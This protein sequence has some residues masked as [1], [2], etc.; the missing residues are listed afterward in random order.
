MNNEIIFETIGES[1]R[2]KAAKFKQMRKEELKE[3]G[4]FEYIP[5]VGCTPLEIPISIITTDDSY[6]GHFL[7]KGEDGKNYQA[8]KG[9]RLAMIEKYM[10]NTKNPYL[11]HFA[12][13]I[14]ERAAI[15]YF[16]GGSNVFFIPLN[17]ILERHASTSNHITARSCVSSFTQGFF[18]KINDLNG[19]IYE[20]RII[21]SDFYD[22]YAESFIAVYSKDSIYDDFT[23]EKDR[24]CLKLAKKYYKSCVIE[25]EKNT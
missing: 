15:R 3:K 6:N 14:G 17:K 25:N 23:D 12:Q 19:T 16:N 10:D 13:Y 21:C 24:V 2:K 1:I 7:C 5:R 20:G 11:Y 4:F 9:S 8:L 22:C 18:K